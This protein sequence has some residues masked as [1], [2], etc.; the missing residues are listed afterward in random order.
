MAFSE[1]ASDTSNLPPL[2]GGPA[3]DTITTQH[4]NCTQGCREPTTQS[5]KG[6]QSWNSQENT[7]I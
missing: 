1:Y 3:S 7:S 4:C 2:Q 5:L 6:V